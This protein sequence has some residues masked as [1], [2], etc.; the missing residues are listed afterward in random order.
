MP[1]VPRD[2]SG[3]TLIKLLGRYGYK[4]TRQ[5][6]SHIRLTAYV[7]DQEHHITIPDHDYVKIGTL[8]N[9]LSN[10]AGA[11]GQSKEEVMKNLF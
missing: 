2:V 5:V 10:L 8:N 4:V 7:Q 11:L 3:Q 1:R 6:G 9:I